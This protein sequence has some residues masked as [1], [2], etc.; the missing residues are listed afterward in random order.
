VRTWV[1]LAIATVAL[2]ASG[3]AQTTVRGNEAR[4]AAAESTSGRGNEGPGSLSHAEDEQFCTSHACIAN[5]PNGHGEVVE[6]TDGKWSHS[7]GVV[8]ACA[9]HGGEKGAD[10]SENS[11]GDSSPSEPPQGESGSESE[12]PGSL[13]H[14][15]DTQFCSSHECIANFA[16]GSG[17]V[18]QC[19]DGEW[20]HSGGISGACSHHGG[21]GANSASTPE[22]GGG[23]STRTASVSPL[24]ALNTYWSDIRDHSFSAAYHL[25]ASGAVSEGESQ[26]V[27]NEQNTH[28]HNA[29][30][31]GEITSRS[32][33][34]AT[35]SVLS[36]AT[37][38]EEFGCRTWS[39]SYTM[40]YEG[41]NWRIEHA[42]LSPQSCYG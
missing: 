17:A 16:N 9:D 3:C 28:I 40:S 5:F 14:A 23:E 30:F 2:L 8:G 12:G 32:S 41:G 10:S 26:F 7:G 6:C 36:L 20:S 11:P 35:V 37:H 24:D 25:L 4:H 27:A 42:A 1:A 22:E 39:G 33:S 29:Q 19:T 18:V 15:E 38:D 34:T 13:S 31:R 21:E